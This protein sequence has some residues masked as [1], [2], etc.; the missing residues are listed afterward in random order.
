MGHRHLVNVAKWIFKCHPTVPRQTWEANLSWLSALPFAWV[1]FALKR[2]FICVHDR[3]FNA[4]LRQAMEVE[5]RALAHVPALVWLHALAM[6]CCCALAHDQD[7]C[8]NTYRHFS[9]TT[10]WLPSQQFSRG[11]AWLLNGSRIL[12]LSAS[13]TSWLNMKLTHALPCIRPPNKPESNTTQDDRFGVVLVRNV[14]QVLCLNVP[15]FFVMFGH[16]SLP[17][18]AQHHQNSARWSRLRYVCHVKSVATNW[19]LPVEQGSI[20]KLCQAQKGHVRPGTLKM[21]G[22]KSYSSFVPWFCFN[23]FSGLH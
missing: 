20:T 10:Q 5:Q 16:F 1:A 7:W 8:C 14:W 6:L 4:E 21:P 17:N 12:L 18:V 23:N 22:L 13:S 9:N 3:H 2:W 19:R 11:V 15:L